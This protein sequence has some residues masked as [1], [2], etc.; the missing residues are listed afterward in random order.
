MSKKRKNV[1]YKGGNKTKLIQSSQNEE[2]HLVTSVSVKDSFER[3]GIKMLLKRKAMTKQRI[4][5]KS[6]GEFIGWLDDR[7]KR[8]ITNT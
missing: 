4:C 6:F 3:I 2:P 1:N 8:R 5:L 7:G